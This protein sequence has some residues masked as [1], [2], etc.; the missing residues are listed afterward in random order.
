MT[1]Q[2]TT[3]PTTLPALCKEILDNTDS[4]AILDC[5]TTGLRGECIDLAIVDTA[6]K[7]LFNELLRPTCPI[8]EG[9]MAVHGITEGM[10]ANAK[11]FAHLW[12]II[13]KSIG[14]RTIIAYNAQFDKGRFEHTA[15]IHGITL[16]SLEWQCLM[17]KY[18]AFYNAP[19][20]RGYAGPAWQKLDA[21]CRQQCVPI[22]QEHRALGDA[23]ATASLIRR[24]AELG[25][26]A[27][28]WSSMA[29]EA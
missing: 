2:Q 16:P 7:V 17:R 9:A 29:V 10:V 20:E 22:E 23:L 6:S 28:R 18:A 11:T 1:T 15:K 8:E 4:Y 25:N 3:Q 27:R 26:A 19:N 24:L 12:P 13:R 5:E 21:A 14:N